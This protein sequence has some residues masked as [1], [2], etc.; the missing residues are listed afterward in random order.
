MTEVQITDIIDRMYA[1][2]P[3]P[4][5]DRQIISLHEYLRPLDYQSMLRVV[6]LAIKRCSNPPVQADLEAVRADLTQEGTPNAPNQ[7]TIVEVDPYVIWRQK[8]LASLDAV[9][10]W[11]YLND[12]RRGKQGEW[13]KRWREEYQAGASADLQQ[14]VS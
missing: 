12:C 1:P 9:A 3:W 5:T 7:A 13:D 14:E 2:Y 6:E 11:E 8:R 4:P 10:Y